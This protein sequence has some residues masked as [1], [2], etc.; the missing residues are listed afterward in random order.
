MQIPLQITFHGIDHSD[1]VEERIR[2]KAQKLEL[3]CD[4]ITSCRV[5]IETHHKNSSA[6]RPF[7]IRIACTLPGTE[8]VVKRDP[9][10]SHV[11]EDIMVALREAFDGMARQ[12]KDHV[13]RQRGEVKPR[14]AQ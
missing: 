11:N 1:A 13:A 14:V 9:K 10:D 2:E 7:H 4:Y 5:V 8:L 3:A 6:L 12:L